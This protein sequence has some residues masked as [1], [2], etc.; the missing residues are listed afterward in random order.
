MKR[1]KFTFL[2][3]LTIFFSQTAFSQ[4]VNNN[5]SQKLDNM[6]KKTQDIVY[7]VDKFFVPK[8]SIADFTRQLKY[9]RAFIINLSGYIRGDA[10][11]KT[12]SDGNFTIMT[13]AVW[14]SQDKLNEAK[15][16]IQSEFKRIGFNPIEFYQR[17]NI[18][19]EREQYEA[20]EE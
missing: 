4:K 1:L 13:I 12:D 18:K 20:L 19:M 7:F 9:N 8:T 2:V 17:L 6:Q 3:G 5:S 15:Q 10:F 11:E 16:S 14:E